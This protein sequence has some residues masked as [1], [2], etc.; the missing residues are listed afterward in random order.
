MNLNRH[1]ILTRNRGIVANE[2]AWNTTKVGDWTLYTGRDIEVCPLIADSDAL[3]GFV[4]GWAYGLSK[5]D[6]KENLYQG[7]LRGQSFE[8]WSRKL[9]G[10]YCCALL[11]ESQ[12]FFL[13]AS[14][15][16]GAVFHAESGTIASTVN[17]TNL[18]KPDSD[19]EQLLGVPKRR[20]WYPFG[21]QPFAGWQRL[22][23]N[24]QLDLNSMRAKRFW[25]RDVPK[26]N[27]T[28]TEVIR[29]IAL[30]VSNVANQ[31]VVPGNTICLMTAGQD[32]RMVL[33]SL[34]S[35]A[36]NI[37]CVTIRH[38]TAELD[39]RVAASICNRFGIR[40]ETRQFAEP[41]ESDRSE[42]IERTGYCINDMVTDLST[43]LSYWDD[44]EI[45]IGG[46]CGE[47][48]RGFYW[49]REDLNSPHPHAEELL[50]RMKMPGES[51]IVNA[52]R[53]WLQTVPQGIST[54]YIW[55]L[56]YV[57][58][59]LGCWAGSS[60]YGAK[61]PVPSMTPFNNRHIF[62]LILSLPD[63]YRSQKTFSYDFIQCSWPELNF[64]PFNRAR[65]I[66][67]LRFLKSEV[68]ALLAWMRRS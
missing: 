64:L 42:W 7:P 55:D 59:R 17:C 45:Q 11:D 40:H 41:R 2:S 22:I 24:F 31:M 13:D 33:A 19:L 38:S 27:G 65:G 67:R 52:A 6:G 16:L 48:A 68:K 43:T 21:L 35:F 5:V 66:Q 62:E 60:V 34:K 18:T 50:K 54:P 4:V 14:G 32:S 3:I 47:I 58:Q 51:K 9:S 49:N 44:S 39:C 10:R 1:F 61:F 28:V 23:P 26:L 53:D 20:G 8:E 15:L 36:A 57:E 29:Q 56:L 37:T 12:S 63:T 25:P 46:T 30:E